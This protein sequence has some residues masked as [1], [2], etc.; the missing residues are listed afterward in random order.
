[1]IA[2][3]IVFIPW[4]GPLIGWIVLPAFAS[5]LEPSVVFPALA[6]S[7]IGAVAIQLVVT[8][9][10]MAGAVNMTPVAVFVVVILGTAVAGIMGAIFAIPTAAAILSVTDYLR[11]RDVLL[12][13]DE[14]E[15]LPA[16]ETGTVPEPDRVAPDAI[17]RVEEA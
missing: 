17:A 14:P 10:V 3:L 12:R 1:M 5:I 7:I 8:Q 15:V 4:I 6:I 11:Q 9:F 2:G 16:V 13:A